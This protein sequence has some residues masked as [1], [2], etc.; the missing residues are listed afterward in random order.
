[1]EQI[2]AFVQNFITASGI[3]SLFLQVFILG[4]VTALPVGPWNII[5]L[6]QTSMHGKKHGLLIAF[7]ASFSNAICAFSV[8]FFFT[9]FSHVIAGNMNLINISIAVM[10]VAFGLYFLMKKINTKRQR[11]SKKEQESNLYFYFKTFIASVLNPAIWVTY[12]F[13]CFIVQELTF[14]LNKVHIFIEFTLPLFLGTW[15]MWSVFII[16]ANSHFF[17]R[18]IPT[19]LRV[20]S[21]G[22]ITAGLFIIYTTTV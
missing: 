4:L 14:D 11:I 15:L 20:F 13:V 8:M 19:V 5:A 2:L 7:T 17:A 12:I 10:L 1:M 6:E 22:F 21:V 9:F 16:I 3:E 18:F